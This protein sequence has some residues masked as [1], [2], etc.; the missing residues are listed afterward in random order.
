MK[1]FSPNIIIYIWKTTTFDRAITK[2]SDI[3]TNLFSMREFFNGLNPRKDVKDMW[4]NIQLGFDEPKKELLVNT[5]WWFKNNNSAIFEKALQLHETTRNFW[6]LF[7]HAKINK[8]Q[9][10]EELQAIMTT[11]FSHS[12]PIAL[13]FSAVKDGTA[14]DQ[15]R[16]DLPKALHI[17]CPKD[18]IHNTQKLLSHTYG[19][20]ST[21][22][23]LGI[24][25]RYVKVH[26]RDIQSHLRQDILKLRSKQD[27]FLHS[28]AHGTSWEFTTIDNM[29]K[30]DKF[31]LRQTLMQLK[32]KDEKAY[33]FLG[34]NY[35]EKESGYTFTFAKKFENDARDMIAQL[36]P[37]LIH[38][39]NQ[40]VVRYMTAD[41]GTRALENPWDPELGRAVTDLDKDHAAFHNECNNMDWL[42]APVYKNMT[43]DASVITNTSASTITNNSHFSFEQLIDDNSIETMDRNSPEK[44]RAL[45]NRINQ[46]E[47]Q[48]KSDEISIIS[49]TQTIATMDSRI[50]LMES[51]ISNMNKMMTMFMSSQAVP[52]ATVLENRSPVARGSIPPPAPV[53]EEQA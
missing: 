13:V 17:D 25:M 42:T 12:F 23:P 36:G 32:T 21:S 39:H 19:R 26:E 38:K 33:L 15:N 29:S 7:S 28:I 20:S 46:P 34:I 31:N 3:T 1:E 6:L 24:R 35:D 43:I 41:A 11:I 37:Y 18:Q 48:Q 51:S 40:T 30:S 47:I 2:D 16:K 9:L 45:S 4:A 8:E 5:S 27:W 49:E 52:P 53:A 14:Y 10:E 50:S 44:R 22:F